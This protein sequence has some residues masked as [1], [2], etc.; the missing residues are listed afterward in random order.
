MTASLPPDYCGGL[1]EIRHVPGSSRRAYDQLYRRGFPTLLRYRRWLLRLIEARPGMRLLDVACGDGRLLERAAE[2]GLEAWGADIAPTA[3]RGAPKAAR[4]RVLLAD[5]QRL[6]FA[7]AAFDRVTNVGSLE[8]F[9]DPLEGVREMA[10]VLRLDGL[11]ALL[12]PNTFGL[13]TN[14]L[15]V[16]RGGHVYDDGQPVQRYGTRRQWARLLEAGGLEVVRVV[17][18]ES[19]GEWPRSARELPALARHPTRLLV[20]LAPLLP[21]DMTSLLWFLCRR[22]RAQPGAWS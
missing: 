1:L 19:R 22:G 21:V 14:V 4:G 6:P 3:L 10:R 2:A 15:P 13:R 8:H 20:P 5:A 16:W 9:D 17:G 7:D 11:A 18:Y 12:L